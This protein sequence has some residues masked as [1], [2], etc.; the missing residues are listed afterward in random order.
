MPERTIQND[1]THHGSLHR[2]S[3]L[4]LGGTEPML[5]FCSSQIATAGRAHR[6][7][8]QTREF[9]FTFDKGDKNPANNEEVIV[10]VTSMQ[11]S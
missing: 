3:A 7:S 5:F 2:A 10:T 1:A 6:E 11:S 9:G 8:S 4:G